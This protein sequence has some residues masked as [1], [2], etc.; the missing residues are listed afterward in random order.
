MRTTS[1]IDYCGKPKI[2]NMTTN[3]AKRSIVRTRFGTFQVTRKDTVAISVV[4]VKHPV[5]H[6]GNQYGTGAVTHIEH[7]KIP[8]YPGPSLDTGWCFWL[9]TFEINGKELLRRKLSKRPI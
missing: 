2:T 8:K 3:S 6:H 4:Q 5:R 7:R 9:A 1:L